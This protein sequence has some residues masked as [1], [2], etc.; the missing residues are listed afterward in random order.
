MKKVVKDGK[1]AVLY[2][3][4]FGEGWYSRYG[5][6][7][8]LFHPD[9]VELVLED[10]QEEI[11]REFLN[12]LGFDVLF[13]PILKIEWVEIGIQFRIEEYDGKEIVALRSNDKYITA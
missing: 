5:Y 4:Y 3:F 10:R 8:L 6:E 7:E 1:V 9:I 11:T 2:S 12:G 13:I